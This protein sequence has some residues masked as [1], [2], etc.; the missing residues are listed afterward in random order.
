MRVRGEGNICVLCHVCVCARVY[1]MCVC[2]CVC[3]CV[4]VCMYMC[5]CVR[6]CVRVYVRVCVCVCV[7]VCDITFMWFRHD[8]E[9]DDNYPLPLTLSDTIA[10]V[11]ERCLWESINF[12]I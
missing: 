1:V 4:N 9:Y 11:R 2:D 12:E 7:C 8:N 3:V 6:V 10:S 5:V